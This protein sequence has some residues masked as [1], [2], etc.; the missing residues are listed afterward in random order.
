MAS[1]D[2]EG[3]R[4]RIL[5]AAVAEFAANGLAGAR[6]EAIAARAGI[7]KQLPFYYFGSK[8]L[9]F[10]A[11]VWAKLEQHMIELREHAAKDTLLASH[12]VYSSD[13][14]LVR[15]LMW[16]A[17]ELEPNR[18]DGQDERVAMYAEW[19]AHI[20]A[21]QAAGTID[22]GLDPR[23][24]VL[25]FLAEGLFPFAFPQLTYL[26]TG[27]E[28]DASSFRRGRGRYIAALRRALGPR[29]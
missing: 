14:D 15:M 17:L 4:R 3:T 21:D 22:P 25:S 10:R 6:M 9:L 26:V 24:L 12:E 8:E 28:A 27:S 19:V 7:S 18:S 23:Q 5:D 2:P 29:P 13:P 1:R 20:R 11:A 16:E